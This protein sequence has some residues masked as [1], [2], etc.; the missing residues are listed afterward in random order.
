M[1]YGR[2]AFALIALLAISAV[3]VTIAAQ[4]SPADATSAL[5]SPAGAG[6]PDLVITGMHIE[7]ETGG[8]CAFSIQLG[9]R[10]DVRNT[11]DAAAGPF[12]VELS[13]KRQTV[14]G[15]AAGASVSP[16]FAGHAEYGKQRALVDATFLVAESDETNNE[17]TKAP[18][19]PTLPA[20]CTPTRTVTP[21]P[22]RTPVAAR[23]DADCNGRVNAVDAALVLQLEAA[24]IAS[25]PCP[26]AADVNGDGRVDS[27]DAFHMIQYVAGL[28]GSL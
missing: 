17:H 4:R 15:L 21:T 25:L 12:V 19:V 18:P 26:A 11:G 10:V 13:G 1:G 22:T 28:V 16:W 6:L 8:S 20:T 27:R 5:G 3:A 24:L 2:T 23:G 14:D 9:V 7:L